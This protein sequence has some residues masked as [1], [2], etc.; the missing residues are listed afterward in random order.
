M[1][2]CTQQGEKGEVTP[3]IRGKIKK[4]RGSLDQ[5]NRIRRKNR[6]KIVGPKNFRKQRVE[7][8]AKEKRITRP[9]PA[10]ETKNLLDCS[11]SGPVTS[12]I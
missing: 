6:L 7:R 11:S 8:L 2:T 9:I 10:G 12:G 1:V 3:A 4:G 5:P